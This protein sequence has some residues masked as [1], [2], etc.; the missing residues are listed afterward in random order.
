M[1]GECIESK[2]P[3]GLV[4]AVKDSLAEIGCTAAIVSVLKKY[5][6]GR[7]DIHA[8]GRQR[9]E[10]VQ[11]NQERSFL[12]GEVI[13]FEDEPETPKKTEIETLA[14]LHG[15]LF[16]IL[17]QEAQVEQDH[18]ML[19]FHLAQELP[20]DLDFKQSL[21]EMKSESQRVTTLIEYYE[22]TIPRVEKTLRARVKAGGN[23]HVH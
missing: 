10:I 4:R 1:I 11:L 16:D 19:S 8:E 17:G 2:R 12:R 7:F 13:F 3:F 21:L 9:F 23:G 18:P 14:R 6:D 22:A 15:R 20:V 5:D